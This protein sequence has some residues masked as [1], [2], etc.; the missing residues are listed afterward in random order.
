[1]PVIA[2]LRG[3]GEFTVDFRPTNY[4]EM[5]TL[6]EPNGSAPL[7][8]LLAMTT[9]EST[10]DPKFNH[11]RDELPNRVITIN[12]ASGYNAAATSL[13]VDAT[14]D[15]NF[16]VPNTLLANVRTGEVMRA[17]ALPTSNGTVITVARNVG[18]TSFTIVDNDVLAIVGFADEENGSKPNVSTWDA[19]VDYNYTQIFKTGIGLSGTLQETYLRTGSKEQEMLQK[20]LKLH[21]SD[22]E[23]TFFWGRRAIENGTTAKPRRYTGGLLTMIPNQIDASSGFGSANTISELEFDRLLVENIFAYGSKQKLVFAGPRVISNLQQIAKARWAPQQ[24][25]GSYGVS[26]TA[27]STFAGDLIVHLH[28]LFRQ[29]PGYE[30]VAVIVDLPYLKYR[31]MQNRDTDLKLNVETP[32]TDGVEHFYQTE[33]GLEM[34]QS[35]PH[36]VIRNWQKIS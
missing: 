34:T 5:Y 14:D 24:V 17:T 3:T 19:T 1:M 21:M 12:E 6:L 23:R 26:M 35:K 31:Y 36:A 2:G 10:D 28:P 15:V 13:T 20:A 9:G 4:R 27:Y 33:C 16:V 30:H 11:F 7:N 22:I 8:A 25:S 29:I 18:G 32:G